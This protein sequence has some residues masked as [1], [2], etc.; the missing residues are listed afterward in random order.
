V[1]QAPAFVAGV[2][3][4]RGEIVLVVGLRGRF[5]LPAV[6]P[7][8]A[9]RVV[10]CDAAGARVG[11]IVD[12][13]SEVLMVPAEAIAATPEVASG[14]AEYLRGIANLGDRLV[15]LLDLDG[16]FGELAGDL[17]SHAA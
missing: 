4:L 5:G 9:T 15:I 12:G 13:V 14:E 16:L 11:L 3:N 2:I 10:V 8:K 1:P 7:T 6:A 17:A